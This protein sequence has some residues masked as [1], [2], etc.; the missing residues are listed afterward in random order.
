[1]KNPPQATDLFQDQKP[2]GYGMLKVLT[3]LTFIGCAIAYIF[4]ILDIASWDDYKRQLVEAQET[5]ARL[6]DSEVASRIMQG[7]VE[8]IQRSHEHRYVL[9]ATGFLFTT[10][11]VMGAVR[12]RRQRKSGYLFY[13]IGELSPLVVSAVLL[14]FGFLGG[15]VMAVSVVFAFLFVILYATQRK[16]LVY[17]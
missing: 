1:M 9:A 4:L 6:A 3:T 7:S 17:N 12:M 11:C 2:Q 5:E 15:I 16:Y 8:M 13:V 14:G 10:L